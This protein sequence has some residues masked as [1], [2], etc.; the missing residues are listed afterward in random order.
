MGILAQARQLTCL[1]PVVCAALAWYLVSV[2]QG[3]NK[4]TSQCT[5][6]VV[7]NINDELPEHSA[8]NENDIRDTQ[9]DNV[10]F[11]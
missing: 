11:T 2:S 3:R 10:K 1:S 7:Q 4:R 9:K 8:R 6:V 5:A